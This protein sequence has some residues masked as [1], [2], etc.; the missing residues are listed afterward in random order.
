[1]KKVRVCCLVFSSYFM[2]LVVNQ[3][4]KSLDKIS[5]LI[6]FTSSFIQLSPVLRPLKMF[7]YIRGLSQNC[8]DMWRYLVNGRHRE[9]KLVPQRIELICILIML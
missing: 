7:M 6:V 9:M 4:N 1:M 2:L 3:T 8:G 5:L